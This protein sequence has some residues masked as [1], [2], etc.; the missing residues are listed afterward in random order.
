MKTFYKNR[1]KHVQLLLDKGNYVEHYY[2]NK[3]LH[4]FI[5]LN[6]INKKRLNSFLNF[7]KFT[8]LSKLDQVVYGIEFNKVRLYSSP[9]RIYLG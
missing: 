7:N 9:T 3:D 4:M 8:L 5:Y 1:E 2:Y 6:S